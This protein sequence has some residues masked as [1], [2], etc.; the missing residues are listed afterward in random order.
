MFQDDVVSCPTV[1]SKAFSIQMWNQIKNQTAQVLPNFKKNYHVHGFN[2]STRVNNIVR[3]VIYIIIVS[4]EEICRCL[5]LIWSAIVQQDH[6]EDNRGSGCYILHKR[7]LLTFKVA[8]RCS[9]GKSLSVSLTAV[10]L[11]EASPE[12]T[13]AEPMC[14]SCCFAV[15]FV[16]CLSFTVQIHVQFAGGFWLVD[17]L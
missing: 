11:R 5:L 6:W 1:Q 17:I 15:C 14:L 12:S 4:K 2:Q 13:G 8:L 3:V 9:I 16:V 7:L 10:S